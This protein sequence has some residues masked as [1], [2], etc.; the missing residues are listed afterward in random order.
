LDGGAFE[1]KGGVVFNF[2]LEGFMIIY[3]SKE[4][5]NREYLLQKKSLPFLAFP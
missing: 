4:N 1:G 5:Y 2:L 3:Y